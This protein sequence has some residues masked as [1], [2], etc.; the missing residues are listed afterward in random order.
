MQL[1]DTRSHV[2]PDSPPKG[3]DAVPH[4]KKS[5]P[6]LEEYM[7]AT[8]AIE[9][10]FD[11]ALIDAMNAVDTYVDDIS[12]ASTAASEPRVSSQA[13][14]HKFGHSAIRIQEILSKSGALRKVLTR[15]HLDTTRH[16]LEAKKSKPHPPSDTSAQNLNQDQAVE[17]LNETPKIDENPIDENPIDENRPAVLT[18]EVIDALFRLSQ[19]L[20]GGSPPPPTPYL[21]GDLTQ[22]QVHAQ[23]Q[24]QTQS[25]SQTQNQAQTHSRS[26]TQNHSQTQSQSR[27]QTQS[28]TQAQTLDPELLI[29]VRC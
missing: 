28:P 25:Q 5:E 13:H 11:S 27:T 22:N 24:T 1:V 2:N 12:N 17:P 18:P 10:A 21:E 8:A 29:Q 7:S 6:T 14:L 9:L 26:Q 15:H 20:P 23:T 16:N 4:K 19:Y 3:R